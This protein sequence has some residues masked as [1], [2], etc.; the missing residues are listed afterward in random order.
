MSI[1]PQTF[2]EKRL[3]KL[4][5]RHSAVGPLSPKNTKIVI[6]AVY[7]MKEHKNSP[8]YVGQTKH[9]AYTRLLEEIK[10]ANDHKSNTSI[11]QFIRRIGRYNVSV[12]IL[13]K[14]NE[15]N[16]LDYYERLWI[17]RLE[18]HVNKKE[19][20]ALNVNWEHLPL[21]RKNRNNKL[22]T[23]K[24]EQ[25]HENVILKQLSTIY[26]IAK[27]RKIANQMP[28]MIGSIN[29]ANLYKILSILT[30]KVI[31]HKF[32]INSKEEE[33]L[34]ITTHNTLANKIGQE[35]IQIISI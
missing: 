15:E 31:K 24:H 13:Q 23:K 30:G 18:T 5:D 21:L 17:H 19:K 25:N 26:H 16:M 20:P 14:V 10:T 28:K 34:C 4:R 7:G 27:Y 6:H 3:A 9:T 1:T 8:I 11:S 32:Y 2:I 33:N 29:L 12:F 35:M 22:K